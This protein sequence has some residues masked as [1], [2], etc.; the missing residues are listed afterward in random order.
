MYMGDNMEA[1]PTLTPAQ[2]RARINMSRVGENAI[3]RDDIAKINAAT[4]NP[5]LRPNLSDIQPAI[6][7]P[8]IAPNA[9]LPV[10]SPSQ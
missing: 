1:M 2:N 9:R 6:K 3:A 4:N 8:M 7:Q 5:G 10:A